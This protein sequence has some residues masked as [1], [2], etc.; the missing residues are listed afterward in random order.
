MSLMTVWNCLQNIPDHQVHRAVSSR[1]LDWQQKTAVRAKMVTWHGKLVSAGRTQTLS[2][3]DVRD[4]RAVVHQ[5]P[6]CLVVLASVHQHTQLVL[7]AVWN[8]KPMKLVVREMSQTVVVF[9]CV[10][11]NACGHVQ[12]SLQPVC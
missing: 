11:D 8:V 3:N 1:Q 6:R 12:Y 10:T 7:H 2:E 5:V 4:W 9:P